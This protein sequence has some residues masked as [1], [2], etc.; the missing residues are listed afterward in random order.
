M[1]SGD[2]AV[3]ERMSKKVCDDERLIVSFDSAA[4]CFYSC[5]FRLCGHGLVCA[6]LSHRPLLN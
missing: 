2:G 3:R 4:C 6:S 5:L 1:S